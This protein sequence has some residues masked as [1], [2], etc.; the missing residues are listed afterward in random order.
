MA[1]C[2]LA[3]V[4]TMPKV[5]IAAEAVADVIHMAAELVE[6]AASFW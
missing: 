4:P 2:P 6:N 1:P 5:G 3:V